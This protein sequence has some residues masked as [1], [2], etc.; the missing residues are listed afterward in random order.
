MMLNHDLCKIICSVKSGPAVRQ[1]DKKFS[2]EIN[3]SRGTVVILVVSYTDYT[4]SEV[5]MNM[6]SNPESFLTVPNLRQRN[7][8]AQK[9][10]LCY[11]YGC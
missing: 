6:V 2:L 11:G 7:V 5:F 10:S 4:V 3:S 9:A 1:I 8:L